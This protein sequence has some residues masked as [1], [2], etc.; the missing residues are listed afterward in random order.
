MRTLP[1]VS[2]AVALL[3]LLSGCGNSSSPKGGGP[4]ASRSATPSASPSATPTA[5]PAT[6]APTADRCAVGAQ[7][8]PQSTISARFPTALAF[9]PDGRLFY[10]ER[11]GTVR[12]W[13]NGGSHVFATVPTVTTE[14]GGGY[15]ERGLLGLAI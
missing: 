15:S 14:S 2:V 11:S 1:R 12:V 13:Q 9:A 5:V 10:A 7:A 4:T 8:P 3:A 6:P